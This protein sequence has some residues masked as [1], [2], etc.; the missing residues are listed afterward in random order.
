MLLRDRYP[1][2]FCYAYSPPGATLSQDASKFAED[3]IL[4]VVIGKD[5]IARLVYDTLTPYVKSLEL[6]IMNFWSPCMIRLYAGEV[7]AFFA[8]HLI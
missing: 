6:H 2:L 5:M 4:S 3:F 7:M 8:S 1:N